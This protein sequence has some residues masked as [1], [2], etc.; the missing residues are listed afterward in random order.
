MLFYLIDNDP[1]C[2][3]VLVN[4]ANTVDEYEFDDEDTIKSMSQKRLSTNSDINPSDYLYRN[5]QA[6]V[7]SNT[8]DD[9][10][11]DTSL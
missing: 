11:E 3:F 1:I 5:R 8:L 4:M 6:V 2:F 7:F 9:G 10:G